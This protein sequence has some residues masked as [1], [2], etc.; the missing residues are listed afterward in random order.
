MFLVGSTS[1]GI[2]TV[3][4]LLSSMNTTNQKRTLSPQETVMIMTDC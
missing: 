4:L 1:V 3:G 2:I